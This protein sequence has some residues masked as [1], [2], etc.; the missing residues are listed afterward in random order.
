MS[1]LPDWL[2]M[3]DAGMAGNN[4]NSQ[5]I[6]TYLDFWRFFFVSNFRDL[7]SG[8][9]EDVCR[10]LAQIKTTKEYFGFSYSKYLQLSSIIFW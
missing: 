8:E 10:F 6:Q 3:G 2:A 7:L 5:V 4:E 9:L 1:R